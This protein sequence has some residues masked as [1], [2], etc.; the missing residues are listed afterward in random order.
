MMESCTTVQNSEWLLLLVDHMKPA[1]SKTWVSC[2]ALSWWLIR[3]GATDASAHCLG[4]PKSLRGLVGMISLDNF[5]FIIV[6]RM[7]FCFHLWSETHLFPKKSLSLPWQ[8]SCCGVGSRVGQD[9][10]VSHVL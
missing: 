2:Q 10:L 6:D 8:V 3:A 4:K 5:L 7:C 9:N 1:A